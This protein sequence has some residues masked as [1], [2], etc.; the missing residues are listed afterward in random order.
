MKT[1]KIRFE[2]DV[3]DFVT[4]NMLYLKFSKEQ[5]E[6]ELYNHLMEELEN[7]NFDE[8]AEICVHNVNIIDTEEEF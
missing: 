5:L 2:V 1:F 7:D 3:P 4:D 6:I 8:D